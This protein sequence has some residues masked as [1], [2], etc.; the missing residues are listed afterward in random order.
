MNLQTIVARFAERFLLPLIER[1]N[2]RAIWWPLGLFPLHSSVVLSE[3]KVGPHMRKLNFP[4]GE[5]DRQQW[6]VCH[7]HYDDPYQLRQMQPDLHHIV[8]VGGNIG[9]F[10]I[11]ARIRFPGALIH[12]YEP[13]PDL[14]ELLQK[15]TAELGITIHAAGVGSRSMTGRM[16][17]GGATI[18][19]ALQPLEDGTGTIR[20]VSIREAINATGGHVDLLKM[21]CEGA[22]WDILQDVSALQDVDKIT[23]EYH[24]DGGTERTLPNLIVHLK[25]AGFRIESMSEAEN[26]RVGQL[27]ATRN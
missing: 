24:L 15:N 9:F 27:L 6:E 14:Q 3:I 23:M 16:D 1:V 21:D 18:E 5:E 8:D 4:P 26:S 20:I 2:Q 22:E 19:G 17:C 10:S 25:H 11:L 12:C 13:N 7:L